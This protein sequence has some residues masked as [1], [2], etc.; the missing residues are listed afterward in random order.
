MCDKYFKER[1][2]VCRSKSNSVTVT[3]K[4]NECGNVY[5]APLEKNEKA[6]TFSEIKDLAFFKR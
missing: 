4:V 5:A 2:S 6:L 1:I 3:L